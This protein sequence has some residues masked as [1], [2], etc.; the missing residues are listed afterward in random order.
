MCTV[1]F[2]FL[3]LDLLFCSCLHQ[4]PVL[5]APK[6]CISEVNEKEESPQG[7]PVNAKSLLEE[8]AVLSHVLDLALLHVFILPCLS[9]CISW[10]AHSEPCRLSGFSRHKVFGAWDVLLSSPANT[11]AGWDL[12]LCLLF[13]HPSKLFGIHLEHHYRE[14][15]VKFSWS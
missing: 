5:P 10:W 12:Q 6:D 14:G 9:W 7:W 2:D 13:S 8:M 15:F 4:A 1:C 3:P 11:E